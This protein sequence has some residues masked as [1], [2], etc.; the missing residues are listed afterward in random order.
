M[1]LFTIGLQNNTLNRIPYVTFAIV[2]LLILA[3]LFIFFYFSH[4]KEQR[5]YELSNQI[6]E[7][8]MPRSEYLELTGGAKQVLDAS[9]QTLE[10]GFE[11]F[12]QYSDDMDD[13]SLEEFKQGF[14]EELLK[15]F[16]DEPVEY[17]D[18][19][20]EQAHLNKLIAELEKVDYG[21]FLFKFGYAPGSPSALGLFTHS[22]IVDG[23][24]F[25]G[26]K[27]MF[28]YMFLSLFESR[29]GHV[30]T[31]VFVYG[32]GILALL[33]DSLT[34][35]DSLM[36]RMGFSG[37][38][39]VLMGATA[40]FAGREKLMLTTST[41]TGGG[42]AI[43]AW[44]V[45]VIWAGFM[46]MMATAKLAFDVFGNTAGL[47]SLWGFLIG[48]GG[49]FVIRVTGLE[50]RFFPNEQDFEADNQDPLS[51][52]L[53][54]ERL[55]NAAAALKILREASRNNPE[56][57]DLLQNHW[58]VASEMR[59]PQDMISAGQR[60]MQNDIDS[61]QVRMTHVRFKEIEETAPNAALSPSFACKVI[62][63]LITE[64][65]FVEAENILKHTFENL[66]SPNVRI[67]MPLME[68]ASKIQ[69]ETGLHIADTLREQPDFEEHDLLDSYVENIEDGLRHG[70]QLQNA[71]VELSAGAESIALADAHEFSGFD[72]AP[73]KN[74]H[75]LKT[76]TAIP[77]AM[78]EKAL[79]MLI[80]GKAEKRTPYSAIKAIAV[81]AIREPG[82]K[83]VLLIDLI[84][85]RLQDVGEN[86]RVMRMRS[87]DF[88]PVKLMPQMS[89]PGEAF[90][91]LVDLLLRGSGAEAYP[92]KD[93]ALGNA[94]RNFRSLR[95][96]E[97]TIYYE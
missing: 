61:G 71:S 36:P 12:A 30:M 97:K 73:K 42:M 59:R 75:S 45:I 65:Y 53:R 69:S 89:S 2:G 67:L 17:G 51:A 93:E 90:K 29:F 4:A 83:P 1:P 24:I 85:D 50:E 20:E 62:D 76:Y 92:S 19:D 78:D 41:R 26:I 5:S 84:F 49:M 56:D 22:F 44:I 25:F 96:Y 58:R 6:M 33:M 81:G 55:G 66:P 79:T 52:A 27:L 39:A 32:G 74:V 87:C 8:Y 64:S 11:Q 46:L 23:Y 70:S 95:E 80:G 72:T 40:V 47:I 77:L 16:G 31:G 28:L 35:P 91:R 18:P 82:K 86:H 43:P 14:R 21:L 13:E 68:L 7:F 60:L 94:Y 9:I 48:G 15:S 3:R 38:L 37:M 63:A 34:Y 57:L 54:E 10:V 88:N